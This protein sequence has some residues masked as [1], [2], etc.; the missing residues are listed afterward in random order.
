M[1]RLR[2][3]LVIL[4]FHSFI[5]RIY[6]GFVCVCVSFF[7]QSYILLFESRVKLYIMQHISFSRLRVVLLVNWKF[8]CWYL[9]DSICLGVSL[10]FSLFGGVAIHV[11]VL[12]C[13]SRT[14][15]AIKAP[16]RPRPC[17]CQWCFWS[18][19]IHHCVI[20]ALCSWNKMSTV[21][22]V[23]ARTASH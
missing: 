9:S 4:D 8:Q 21:K 3:A 6:L 11:L 12:G 7:L 20:L 16:T 17:V 13:L 10:W 18:F 1:R 2:F 19:A 5:R 15:C 22:S 23:L 14:L